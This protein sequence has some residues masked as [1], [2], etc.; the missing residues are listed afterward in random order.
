MS[1]G[2]GCRHGLDPVS[3][4]LWCRPAVIAPIDPLA[5]EP[6]YVVVAALEK[7]KKKGGGTFFSI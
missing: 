1:C 6:P 5:W 3:L 7:T 2:I 4:W